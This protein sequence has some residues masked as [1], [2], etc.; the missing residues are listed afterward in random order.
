LG[1]RAVTTSCKPRMKPGAISR[2][3][4]RSPT[5]IEQPEANGILPRSRPRSGRRSSTSTSEHDSHGELALD[6]VVDRRDS[7][8]C[9]EGSGSGPGRP[10]IYLPSAFP[11]ALPRTTP[12][13]RR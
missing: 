7:P 12:P 4:G 10:E 8:N 13:N 5:T 2:C 1:L 3:D 9:P 6:L 11:L